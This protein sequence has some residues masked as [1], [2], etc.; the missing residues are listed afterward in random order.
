VKGPKHLLKIGDLRPEEIKRLIRRGAQLKADWPLGIRPRPLQDLN[1][2]L[3]FEKPSTR[4]R[5]S[6]EAGINQLGGSAIFLSSGASQLSRAEPLRDTARVLSRYVQ[7]MVVR[8]FGQERVEELAAFASV[9]VI[10]ALTD[11]HHPCQV[12]SDLMTVQEH[13]GRIEG[14]RYCWLGDGNNMANS[15]I[16]AAAIMGLSLTLACPQGYEPDPG[17]MAATGG[18]NIR[19]TQDAEQAMAD[20]D[21]V[22]TDVWASMGQEE[23]AGARI[24]VFSRYRLDEAL[25]RKATAEAIVL[26]CLPAHRGEEIS[27]GV[28]EGRQAQV[29]TQAENRLHLQKALLEFLLD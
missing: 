19:L 13:F 29:W 26:H 11:Q 4:T 21:V 18:D 6:F 1:V 8:T 17:V 2:A 28:L 23:E 7:A 25:L 14:L 5:V 10:N 3:I 24:Q 15:W 27:A 22:S 16:E 12:L 9:P 20:A